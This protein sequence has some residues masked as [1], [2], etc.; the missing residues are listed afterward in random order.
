MDFA[1]CEFR[2]DRFRGISSVTYKHAT[3]LECLVG[4]MYL[5]DPQR[6]QTLMLHLGLG[7]RQ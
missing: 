2:P 4:Y 5:T 6:L 1:N 7:G 3:A